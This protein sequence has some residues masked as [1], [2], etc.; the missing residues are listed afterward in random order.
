MTTYIALLRGVNVGNIRIKMD[1]LKVMCANIGLQK[2]ETFIQSGN[3]IFQYKKSTTAFLENKIAVAIKNTFGFTILVLVKEKEALKE[4]ISNNPFIKDKK[5]DIAFFHVTFLAETPTESL[6][7]KLI[8]G[9]YEE[10]EFIIVDDAVYLYCPNSYSKSKL[11]NK[12]LETKLKVSAT[13]R[14]WKTTNKLL[15]I[16]EKIE[17]N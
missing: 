3:I 14:N 1:A 17:I 10:D 13:T 5:K 12:F 16:I 9:N 8:E 6:Y 15:S 7:N 2:V 11:T 4:I